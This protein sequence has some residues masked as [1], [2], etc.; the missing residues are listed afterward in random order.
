[1]GL[2]AGIK[3]ALGQMNKAA[4]FA[5]GLGCLLAILGPLMAVLLY[6]KAK[7]L[8]AFALIGIAVIILN[9]LLAKDP[10]PQELA[11]EIERILA[12]N[13]WGWDIDDF[14]HQGIRDR[15]LRELWQRSMV[16]GGLPEEWSRLN[17]GKKK[18]LQELIRNLRELG[19]AQDTA[20]DTNTKP[21]SDIS[22][23]PRN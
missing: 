5:S 13:T 22:F 11:D 12:G 19:E 6:P 1:M 10:K 23:T 9:S 17:E 18:Q 3:P 16:I 15:Q 8:F 4:K 2:C 7:W 20:S 14:E 21:G